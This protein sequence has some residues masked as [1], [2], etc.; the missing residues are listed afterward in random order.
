MRALV[1]ILGLSS[2]AYAQPNICGIEAPPEEPA[3][4]GDP[5]SLTS[6]FSFHPAVDVDLET[7]TGRFRLT[8]YFMPIGA[9]GG[10]E[11][12]AGVDSWCRLAFWDDP[13]QSLWQR[14]R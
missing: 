10:I 6:G 5:V 13:R 3:C 11:E 8:R 12:P 7:G 2:V 9:L 1:L 14:L 4:R